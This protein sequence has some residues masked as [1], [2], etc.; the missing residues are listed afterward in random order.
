M[1][2]PDTNQASQFN[3]KL[4]LLN[5]LIEKRII[6]PSFLEPQYRDRQKLREH[7]N[8]GLIW[9]E[10]DEGYF[11]TIKDSQRGNNLGCW[12]FDPR[13]HSQKVGKLHPLHA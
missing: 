10:Q 8:G 4:Y 1:L 9:I 7:E 12:N 13:V 2:S 5:K 11:L 6:D 3:L